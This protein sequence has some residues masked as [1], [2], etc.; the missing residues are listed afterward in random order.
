MT[1]PYLVILLNNNNR[2]LNK[3][4]ESQI[5]RSNRLISRNISYILAINKN[6]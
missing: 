2:I 1:I 3:K 5:E 6:K 4:K